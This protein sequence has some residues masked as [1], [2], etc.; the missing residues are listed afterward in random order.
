MRSAWTG[1][2]GRP[3]HGAAAAVIAVG[4]MLGQA[5]GLLHASLVRHETCPQHGEQVEIGG[6]TAF[7]ERTSATDTTVAAIRPADPE[8]PPEHRHCEATLLPRAAIAGPVVAA[9]DGEAAP[10]RIAL[11]RRPRTIAAVRI[12]RLA[13]KQSPPIG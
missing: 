3:R 13:P 9:A 2:N 8:L 11:P 1:A 5:I 12:Y 6:A 10:E 7:A 4:L